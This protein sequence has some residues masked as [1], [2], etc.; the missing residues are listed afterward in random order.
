MECLFNKFNQI[1]NNSTQQKKNFHKFKN[2][3]N[4]TELPIFTENKNIR[5]ENLYCEY[6]SFFEIFQNDFFY[7]IWF[8]KF[9]IPC[10]INLIKNFN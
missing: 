5:I 9:T 8:E 3:A 1:L 4:V 7:R 2:C 6:Y 10:V